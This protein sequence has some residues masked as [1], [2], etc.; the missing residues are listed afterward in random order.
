MLRLFVTFSPIPVVA[1]YPAIFPFLSP[2]GTRDVSGTNLGFTGFC[3]ELCRFC[4]L[5]PSWCVLPHKLGHT[6]SHGM[7]HLCQGYIFPVSAITTPT[8][9]QHLVFLVMDSGR[10][11]FEVP[12]RCHVPF[13]QCLQGIEYS[14]GLSPLFQTMCCTYW[15]KNTGFLLSFCWFCFIRNICN[16]IICF[17]T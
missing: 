12:H 17:Y 2:S 11:R 4:T 9:C 3:L 13:Q 6:V 15:R 10:Q 14:C 16:R 1:S 8:V 7:P 5:F